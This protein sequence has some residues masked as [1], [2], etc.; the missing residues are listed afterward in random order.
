L[1]GAV[2]RALEALEELLDCL[3][4]GFEDGDRVLAASAGAR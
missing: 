3:V 1:H 4:I 2:A